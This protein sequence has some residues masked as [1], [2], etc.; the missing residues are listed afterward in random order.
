MAYSARMK[1]PAWMASLAAV[2]A[3]A[4]LLVATPISSAS[5][6]TEVAAADEA[7]VLPEPARYTSVNGELHLKVIAKEVQ[8]TIGDETYT[9]LLTYETS[10]VDGKGTYTPGTTSA[11]IGPTWVVQ[12][13]DHIVIDYINA[14][15]DYSFSP[16]QEPHAERVPSYLV[17]QPLSLHLH[18]VG[19][20]PS[21][22]ADNVL[23]SIPPGRSN[24]YEFDI[25]KTQAQGLYWYHPHIHGLAD[26]QIYNGLAGFLIIGRADGN[27]AQ[28]DDLVK[29]EVA[30]RYNVRAPSYGRLIDAPANDSWGTALEPRG[31]MVYTTNGAVDPRVRLNAADP[32]KGLPAESQIWSLANITG[33]ATYIVALDEVDAADAQNASVQGTPR[34]LVIVS[35]DGDPMPK[36]IVLTGEDAARGYLIPQGGR[37][38]ILVQGASAPGKVVR[39]LQVENRSGTG[40]KS[41]YNWDDQEFIGG[42]RD[43]TQDVFMSSYNDYSVTTK[44]ANT[45]A[46]LTPNYN[47]GEED[48]SQEPVAQKRTFVFNNVTDPTIDTPNNFGVDFALFPEGPVSQPRVGTVEEWTILN[49]SPL[50]HPFHAH[51]QDAQVME[52]DSPTNPDFV[53]PSGQYV[54]AQY[55]TDMNQSSPSPFQ[56]DVINI[57]PAAVSNDD[58]GMPIVDADG[59]PTQPGKIVL[60]VRVND[61]L[62]WYVEH[63]HRLPHED[64]GMMTVIRS[65]PN[66]PLV[67]AVTRGTSAQ[68]TAWSSLDWSQIMQVTPFAGQSRVQVAV[69][70]VNAD[71]RPDV[72]AVG[73]KDGK[74]Y[75]KVYSNAQADAV[76]T[77]GPF[78]GLGNAPSIALTDI[79]GDHRD[80]VILGAGPNVAPK[81]VVAAGGSG[82]VL[83][84]FLAYDKA[85]RGGVSVA[86][87]MVEE[88]GRNS[89]IT[90]SGPGMRATVAVWNNDLFGN[91]KGVA[92]SMSQIG[93]FKRVG[94]YRIGSKGYDGG[95]SVAVGT[96]RAAQGGLGQIVATTLGGSRLEILAVV[97]DHMAVM[98]KLGFHEMVSETGVHLA[99]PYDAFGPRI[100]ESVLRLSTKQ[101]GY[102]DGARTGV[103]STPTGARMLFTPARGNGPLTAVTL[104]A[105]G[106]TVVSTRVVQQEASQAGG[107]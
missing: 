76:R 82:K 10:L 62:G 79:D 40:V 69:G 65:I 87:G 32:S 2:A 7:P 13:G 86:G 4:A 97:A 27:Y 83:G 52:V 44:H 103:V 9:D 42:W 19:V 94:S 53:N 81:V 68:V 17:P 107:M 34:D 77:L 14:L 64:R 89:I 18:G 75:V 66:D 11:Y 25:P 95:V 8:G 6:P 84:S 96:P 100:V 50:L 15:P 45:P 92:P 21:G 78:T 74:A 99:L 24:R 56:Q 47:P 106:R 49:Y 91:G 5:V 30:L 48:L 88:G 93:T 80:D 16:V 72:A 63:C 38:S 61:F 22:N 46:T 3:V 20:W 31:S 12:P 73:V 58:S 98:H 51:V 85:F 60:R 41:A 54:S 90:G 36:P 67:A 37:V 70:D 55:V 104:G 1:V 35:I 102:G 101:W 59:V 71:A 39:L 43:Y 28:F 29:H 105:D 23:L 26:A 57:P 33:S